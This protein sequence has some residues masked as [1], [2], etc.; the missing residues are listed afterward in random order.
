MFSFNVDMTTLVK[1]LSS[2]T[3]FISHVIN[4][5]FYLYLNHYPTINSTSHPYTTFKP[6][7]LLYKTFAFIFKWTITENFYN[8]DLVVVFANGHQHFP[9]LVVLSS[10]SCLCCISISC[11]GFHSPLTNI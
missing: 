5:H 1:I 11:I 10:L 9:I 8:S 4:N 6:F 3:Q 7:F 2:S